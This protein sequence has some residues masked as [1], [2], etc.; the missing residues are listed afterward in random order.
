MGK[1]YLLYVA[2]CVSPSKT[3]F[4]RLRLNFKADRI[5]KRMH[6][7]FPDIEQDFYLSA[8]SDIEPIPSTPELILLPYDFNKI[9]V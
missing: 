7:R 4:R 9:R 8:P 2:N 5:Q 1:A 6:S 3:T